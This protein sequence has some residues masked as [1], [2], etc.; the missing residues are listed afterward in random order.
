MYGRQSEIAIAAAAR[1]AEVY[2]GGRT[3]LSAGTIARDRGLQPPFVAKLLTAL[4]RGGIVVST[5]GPGGGYW[6][7]RPP[8]S[9]TIHDVVALFERED[10]GEQGV[11]AEMCHGGT[12]CDFVSRLRAL[13]GAMNDLTRSTTLDSLLESAPG[14]PARSTRPDS[15]ATRKLRRN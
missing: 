6:L 8:G 11:L 3:R 7:A 2:D 14:A 9:I 5:P 4:A 12:P 10:T 1:L 13:Q 15:A